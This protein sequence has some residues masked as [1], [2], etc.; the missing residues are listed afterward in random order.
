MTMRNSFYK[1]FRAN[2]LSPPIILFIPFAFKEN[3][4][5]PICLPPAACYGSKHGILSSIGRPGVLHRKQDAMQ[6]LHLDNL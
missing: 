3:E 1:T 4:H 2:Q 5:D 6:Q